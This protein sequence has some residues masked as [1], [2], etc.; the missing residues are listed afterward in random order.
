MTDE[1]EEHDGPSRPA[2]PSRHAVLMRGVV[3][4][5]FGLL[6]VASVVLGLLN[7]TLWKPSAQV[8]A[9]AAVTGTR[10][11]LTDP[12]VLP[13]VDP[14]V[15]VTVR[16]EAGK[17]VC[18]ALG[19]DKD[20]MGW[21]AG[22]EATRITGLDDWDA[23]GT[24]RTAAPG[25][26]GSGEGD[27]AFRDSDM[28]TS[29]SCGD[30]EVS[31][32]ADE[33]DADRLALVDLGDARDAEV[34]MHWVRHVLPDFAMPLYFV[35][36]LCA[37]LAALSASV[38]AMPA[39]KR[40]KRVV[41]SEPVES[42]EEVSVGQ[43]LAGSLSGLRTAVEVRP[44]RH[45]RHAARRSK[46]R[47]SK[48]RHARMAE[49]AMTAQAVSSPRVIDPAKRTMLDGRNSGSAASDELQRTTVI[50]SDELQE[51]FARLTRE[52]AQESARS[53]GDASALL[54][55]GEN[56][57]EAM[58]AAGLVDGESHR[59]AVTSDGFVGYGPSGEHANSG[60]AIDGADMGDGSGA[61]GSVAGDSFGLSDSGV[62]DAAGFPTAA[63][64]DAAALFP[65]DIDGDHT[66]MGDAGDGKGHGSA[67]GM[68]D[69][70]EEATGN[71][72]GDRR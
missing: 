19:S 54:R 68:D 69:A 10:Y 29:V 48:R 6:A 35:G 40:R 39:H 1:H 31:V 16:A 8:T 47:L 23:L 30:G 60:R 71:G 26:D 2:R 51:Y 18:V 15:T 63:A 64:G 49:E 72:E 22:H 58:T 46:G 20:V 24:E 38:F 41:S 21:V 25:K 44:R 11:V 37:V 14:Q 28:W 5:V 42:V 3:A 7:A 43:A 55:D 12:A 52:M 50:G 9:H 45:A 65:D 27:V 53:Q 62:S 34:T 57:A 36:V 56:G 67:E 33:R 4:P 70:V 61:D 66:V 17:P 13:L 32:R 59:N